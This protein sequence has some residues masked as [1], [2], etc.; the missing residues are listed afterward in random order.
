MS[1]T[2]LP[3]HTTAEA[4]RHPETRGIDLISPSERRGGPRDLLAVWAA[5]NISVLSLTVGTSLVLVL[6]LEI[7]Q[8]ILLIAVSSVLWAFPGILATSGPAVGTSGSVITRAIYG[9]NGNRVIVALLGWLISGVFLAL[10]WVAS[11]FMGGELVTRLGIGAGGFYTA[12]GVAIVIAAITVL[13]AVYG[14]ALILRAYTFVTITLLVVFTVA[15][16]FL[17][18]YMDLSFAQPE[19]LHGLELWSSLSIGFAILASTPLSYNNSADLARYLPR[20]ASPTHIALATALG[21]A[22]TGFLATA[23]GTLLATAVGAQ[24]LE[25][26]IEYALLDL[27]PGWFGPVFVGAIILNTIALNGMTTYT[28]SMALQ[29]VGV[30]IRRIPSAVLIGALGTAFTIYLA[31]STSLID[32]VNLMLQFLLIVS[33]PSITIYAVDV[34]LRRNQYDA[35]DLFDESRTSRYWYRAGFS[36]AGLASFAFG[37]VATALFLSTDVWT[38]PLA[39]ALGH[40]DLSVPV[41]VTVSALVY[42]LL[43][44]PGRFTWPLTN[45]DS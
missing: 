27:L 17:S 32:A 10:N 19:P 16:A 28:A 33:V 26:G 36:V 6:G 12:A 37:A 14:H 22:V 3:P 38:G 24:A 34:L 23:A 18:P 21:G 1:E 40:I 25:F 8:A 11:T 5:P 42:A 2:V 44:R 9:I 13:V 30:P 41:G 39:V 43:A 7:W 35:F 31:A 15:I 45:Q 4:A 20:S 29:A